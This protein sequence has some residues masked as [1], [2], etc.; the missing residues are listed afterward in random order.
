MTLSSVD[1]AELPRVRSAA[2]T[3]EGASAPV[4]PSG[5]ALAPVIRLVTERDGIVRE[6]VPGRLEL[7]ASRQL[8]RRQR[9]LWA[10]LGLAGMA[11]TLGAT[12]AV[13]ELVH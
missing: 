1:T 4:V 11:A 7:R 13:L 10:A 8:A 6:P 5:P 9:R 12:I 2:T 3:L